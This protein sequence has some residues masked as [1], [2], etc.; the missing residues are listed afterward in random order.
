MFDDP[1]VQDRRG[2][3]LKRKGV[4][5]SAGKPAGGGS[6]GCAAIS[7]YKETLPVG[8]DIEGPRPRVSC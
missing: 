1:R 7:A 2:T 5:V 3:R 6:P 8:R 4:E